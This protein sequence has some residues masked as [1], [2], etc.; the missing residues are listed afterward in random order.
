M[1]YLLMITVIITV[2]LILIPYYKLIFKDKCFY[3][4]ILII[5]Y[6]SNRIISLFKEIILIVC[7]VKRKLLYS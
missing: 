5:V 1:T 3:Y 2:Y 4:K 7:L 6:E